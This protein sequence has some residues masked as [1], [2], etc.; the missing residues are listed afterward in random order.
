MISHFLA[1]NGFSTGL[2]T[3]GITSFAASLASYIPLAGD[4]IK[5]YDNAVYMIH[6]AW[7]YTAGDYIELRK[8]ADLLE[9]LSRITAKKYSSTS[10]KSLEDIIQLMN[11]TTYFFGDEILEAG[12]V[13]ELIRSEEEGDS[14]S[15]KAFAME[16]VKACVK[17]MQT[18]NQEDKQNEI[19]ALL[20]VVEI[21]KASAKIKKPIKGESKMKTFTEEEVNALETK[22]AEALETTG[23]DAVAAER[24]RVSG[25]MGLAGDDAEKQKSIESGLSIG[26]TAIALNKANADSIQG[27]KT[28]F[29]QAAD[30]LNDSEEAKGSYLS[31]EDQ[32]WKDAESKVYGG[33]K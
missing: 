25:I 10:G 32:A 11:D 16:S 5:A 4:T 26:D 29:E 18:M 30:D 22:H 20:K 12:F 28:D 6:N 24:E 7:L 23:S 3:T 31:K 13:D 27:K 19:A 9:G 14:V 21:P 1:F 8:D 2:G 33:Q 15:S 17:T